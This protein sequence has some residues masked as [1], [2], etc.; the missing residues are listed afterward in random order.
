MATHLLSLIVIYRPPTL[1]LHKKFIRNDKILISTNLALVTKR[2]TSLQIYT[3]PKNL[4]PTLEVM[5]NIIFFFT[6]M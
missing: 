1:K 3:S 5:A 4:T 6:G 2:Y